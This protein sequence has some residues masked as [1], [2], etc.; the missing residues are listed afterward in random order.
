MLRILKMFDE[1]STQTISDYIR[2]D[3]RGMEE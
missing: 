3:K 1:C 2:N